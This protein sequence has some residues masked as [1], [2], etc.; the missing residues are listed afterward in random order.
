MTDLQ[1]L[2]AESREAGRR[3]HYA[4]LRWIAR[5]VG[6]DPD[7]VARCLDRAR[8]TDAIEARRSRR[9]RRGRS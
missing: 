1:K 2:Y 8:Q 5:K 3:G 7:T 6:F 4:S 9:V